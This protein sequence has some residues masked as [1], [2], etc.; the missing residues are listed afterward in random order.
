MR[1]VP[2]DRGRTNRT[3]LA[4]G[5]LPRVASQFDGRIPALPAR[6]A[7][8]NHITVRVQLKV[9]HASNAGEI[10]FTNFANLPVFTT[11]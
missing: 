2:Q 10:V 8:S 7:R 5:L 9:T 6:Q 4:T 3:L 1:L 11:T